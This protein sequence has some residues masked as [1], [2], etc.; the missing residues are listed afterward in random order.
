MTPLRVEKQDKRN[1][2]YPK[3]A[4]PLCGGAIYILVEPMGIE[5]DARRARREC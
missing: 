5:R 3:K 4:Y 2:H 1:V